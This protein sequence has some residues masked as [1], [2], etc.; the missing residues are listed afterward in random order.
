MKSV[1]QIDHTPPKTQMPKIG[2]DDQ[3]LA[4]FRNKPLQNEP[5]AEHQVS[6]KAEDRP[7]ITAGIKAGNP[8]L[9]P[10]LDE[11]SRYGAHVVSFLVAADSRVCTKLV[12][13]GG[14]RN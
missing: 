6:S 4:F 5:R 11:L 1:N 9:Q 8:V 7:P 13:R 3:L 12:A 2:R 10:G 14:A